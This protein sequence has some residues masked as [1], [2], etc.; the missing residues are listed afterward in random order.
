MS[1]YADLINRLKSKSDKNWLTKSQMHAFET[2]KKS[3]NHRVINIFGKEGVGKTFLGWVLEKENI[4]KYFVDRDSME[5]ID[6]S[7]IT[8]DNFPPDRDAHRNFRRKMGMRGIEKA[9]LI[10]K[11]FAIPD[12]VKKVELNFDDEDRRK[13]KSN[14]SKNLRVQFRDESDN[15]N[16]HELLKK[17]IWSE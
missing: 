4:A 7:V 8:I 14:C 11:P 2:I 6:N 9:I 16:M 15:Y 3:T 12:D 13:F 17:N 5:K 1:K 10:T